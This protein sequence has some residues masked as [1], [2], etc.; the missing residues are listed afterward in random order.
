MSKKWLYLFSLKQA[1]SIAIDTRCLYHSANSV[2]TL[3][4][5]PEPFKNKS[6]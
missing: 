5:S 6:P 1:F 4:I 3:T 2:S